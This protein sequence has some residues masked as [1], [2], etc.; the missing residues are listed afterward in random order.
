MEESKIIRVA[1]GIIGNDEGLILVGE[2]VDM[3]F[4]EFPG[5]KCEYGE[6]PF[7]CLVRELK[8]ELSFDFDSKEIVKTDFL[9]EYISER[10][11][12]DLVIYFYMILI[13]GDFPSESDSHR[14]LVTSHF[15]DFAKVNFLKTNIAFLKQDQVFDKIKAFF[16]K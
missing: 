7:H 16:S 8:E 4:W 15:N 6:N 2:R 12:Y 5:G 11:S 14:K 9:A 1:A 13:T 10:D 3:D